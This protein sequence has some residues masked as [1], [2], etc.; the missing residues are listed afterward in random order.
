M[1][2]NTPKKNIDYDEIADTYD[3]RYKRAYGP[4][5]IA[6][7]LLGL[8]RDVEAGMV[9]EIGCGTGHWLAVLKAACPRIYGIDFSLGMLQKARKQDE[10]FFLVRA[11]ANHIPFPDNIFDLVFCVNALH[12]FDNPN[13]FVGETRR[14][15]KNGG[16]LS[17]IG[18]NPHADRDRWFIYD[19]FQG[20]YKTDLG[21]YPSCGAI[22]DWMIAAG[23]DRVDWSVGERIVASRT[24][25]EIL[26]EPI[27]RKN[28]TSQLTLLTRDAYNAGIDRIEAAIQAA[29]SAGEKIVF[30]ADI[31]LAMVT[32]WVQGE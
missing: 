22:M 17:V 20:T 1:M 24:G 30:K 11:D 15:L 10:V 16:A 32:A 29:E 27:L 21:R 28:G 4:G 18:M 19:Y 25:R 12:H 14:L 9:L 5:G 3:Q 2:T 26:E 13:R 7:K 8:A 31:S 23:F 6:A